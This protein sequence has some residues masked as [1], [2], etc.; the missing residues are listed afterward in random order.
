[1][2]SF[3]GP[4]AAG[5][6]SD[7]REKTVADKEVPENQP[8]IELREKIKNIVSHVHQARRIR[9]ERERSS[10]PRENRKKICVFIMNRDCGAYNN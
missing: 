3:Q 8:I 9:T 6:E 1:M 7:S 2:W 4:S 10:N 5:R